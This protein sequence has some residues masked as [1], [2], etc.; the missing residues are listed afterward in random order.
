[1]KFVMAGLVPA[2]HVFELMARFMSWTPGTSSAKMR[3][4][5]GTTASF[6]GLAKL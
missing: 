5:P 3:F 1:M 4:S 2:I 6:V